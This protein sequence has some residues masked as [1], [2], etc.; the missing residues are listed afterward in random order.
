MDYKSAG[1]D[2]DAGNEAVRRIRALANPVGVLRIIGISGRATAADETAGRAAGMDAYLAKPLAKPAQTVSQR[3]RRCL[4]EQPN[5]RH[6]RLLRTRRER[7]RRRR[8]A[9]RG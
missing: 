1:V 5:H 7:P 6:R 9:E 3:V 4:V 2:I 8:A